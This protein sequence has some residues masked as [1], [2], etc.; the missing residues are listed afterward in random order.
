MKEKIKK[1]LEILEKFL[2]FIII[3]LV[4]ISSW[5]FFNI[6]GLFNSEITEYSI[7]CKEK[8]E[9]NQCENPNYPLN[10]TIYKV[11][12]Q[13]QEVVYWINDFPPERLTKCA[14][15]DKKNWSCKYNDESAE[16]GFRNGIFYEFSLKQSSVSEELW[17]KVYYVSRTKY[18]MISCENK[19]PCFLLVNL[20]D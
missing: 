6:S 13:R 14:I 10:K 19:I 8:V 2:G 18:L 3:L 12:V 1:F 20:L 17:N 5:K 15:R 7:M 4:I 11:L 9:W 16:F